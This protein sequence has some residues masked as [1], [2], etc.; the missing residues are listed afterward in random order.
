MICARSFSE[1][2]AAVRVEEGMRAP[3]GFIDRKGKLVTPCQFEQVRSF[4]GGMARVWLGDDEG[5][6]DRT[7]KFVWRA[8]R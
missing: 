6:I 1:S 5:Y 4:S 8:K 3:W 2:L 7:G